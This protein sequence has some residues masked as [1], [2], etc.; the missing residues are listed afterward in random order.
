M[1]SSIVTD[2]WS[3]STAST[4]LRSRGVRSSS[5]AYFSAAASATLRAA[6]PMQILG[7]TSGR[8]EDVQI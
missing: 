5:F 7:S 8:C 6:T 4:I 3:F 2:G 1:A